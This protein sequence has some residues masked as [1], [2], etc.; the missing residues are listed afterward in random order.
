MKPLDK[1]I[2]T[3]CFFKRFFHFISR[4]F[5]YFSGWKVK[6]SL[7]DSPKFVLVAAPHTSN[8][9]FF[10][11]LMV[12]FHFQLPAYW[13]GKHT[14]FVCP[15]KKLLRLFGGIS[16]E[17]SKSRDTVSIMASHFKSCENLVLTIAPSGTRKQTEQWKSGFYHIAVKAD[18]PIVLGYID[19]ITRTV[20][21][22]PSIIPTGNVEKQITD[23]QS[24]YEPFGG[25]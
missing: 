17:R 15:V 23:I 14:M 3:N 22:G 8:W 7:P 10:F 19:Y 9:D 4:I 25:R 21:I 1:V 16:I 11:F 24:F 12:V 20:G 6:G 2:L 13:M 5:F 18:V